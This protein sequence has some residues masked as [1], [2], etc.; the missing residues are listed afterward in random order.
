MRELRVKRIADRR[1]YV[2]ALRGVRLSLHA[3]HDR[4]VAV[5]RLRNVRM[6]LERA[7]RTDALDRK[8]G[9]VAVVRVFYR[10]IRKIKRRV[11]ARNI[12]REGL[13]LCGLKVIG[14]DKPVPRTP[15]L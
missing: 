4:N 9:I 5:R 1:K 13:S 11:A 15:L 10:L 8:A 12:E 14:C 6:R 2:G 3:P 7:R